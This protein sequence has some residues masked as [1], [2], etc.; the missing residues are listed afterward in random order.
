MKNQEDKKVS[1]YPLVYNYLS[2]AVRYPIVSLRCLQSYLKNTFV[3]ERYYKYL[4]L[5]YNYPVHFLV[6]YIA[7]RDPIVS[8][9][10][11]SHVRCFCLPI[12]DVEYMKNV[13]RRPTPSA[14]RPKTVD[15]SRRIDD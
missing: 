1:T 3:I 10:H 8:I 12:S 11:S 5:S 2:D 13:G 4:S 7:F 9:V 14:D 6:R 15:N